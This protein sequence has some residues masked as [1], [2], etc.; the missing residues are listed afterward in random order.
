MLAYFLSSLLYSFH[1]WPPVA[2]VMPTVIVCDANCIHIHIRSVMPTGLIE[3]EGRTSVMVVVRHT[4]PSEVPVSY[5]HTCTCMCMY[6]CSSVGSKTKVIDMAT[7]APLIE[8]I[9]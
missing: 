4:P 3:E 8:I 1:A 7:H 6:A 9:N 2:T 5:V